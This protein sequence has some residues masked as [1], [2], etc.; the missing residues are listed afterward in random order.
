MSD[1]F[2]GEIRMFGFNFPPRGWATCDGQLLPISQ[3][4]AVF[5]L[6]GTFYGG[7]GSTNFALPDFRGRVPVHVGGSWLMGMGQGTTGV[8]LTRDQLP[9][10]QHVAKALSGNANSAFAP[11]NSLA[12]VANLYRD[13]TGASVTIVNPGTVSTVGGGQPHE[14]M[15]PYAVLSFCIALQGVF[16]SRN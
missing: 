8:T 9:A 1:P 11:D 14:N 5:S 2:T 15:A 7:N 12:S 6:L 10:H 4:T 3:N 16:P 13:P